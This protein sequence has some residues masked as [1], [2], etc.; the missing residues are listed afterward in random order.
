MAA[1]DRRAETAGSG[2]LSPTRWGAVWATFAGGVAAGA[3]IG[4]APPSLPLV[5]EEMSLS[6]VEVG[7]VATLFNLIGG[8]AGLAAG[9]A[10]DRW[11]QQRLAVAGLLLLAVGGL[12]GATSTGYGALL[13]ARFAEGAGF[14]VVAAAAPVLVA[15]AAPAA[16]DRAR[17]LALWSTYMPT[18]ATLALAA[19]A[20][21]LPHLGWRGLWTA[22]ALLAAIGA[23][24][25]ARY[26][27]RSAPHASGSL[28]L[29]REAFGSPGGQVLTALFACY[30]AQW[31]SV[32]IWLPTYVSEELGADAA[33]AAAVAALYV[34][35]N[36]PGNL[37]GG[38]LIARGLV[39]GN[40]IVAAA[41]AGAILTALMFAPALPTGLRFVALLLYSAVLGMIPA[42][43]FSGV[44]VL[45]R[46]PHHV[47][48][49]NGLVMQGS[50]LAQLLAPV[51]LAAL[52]GRLGWAAFAT[53]VALFAAGA[54]A[55]GVGVKRLEAARVHG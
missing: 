15:L 40:V 44:P 1:Q 30:V 17:A 31:T 5:R 54:I 8:V 19:A 55:C 39:R 50:Q 47:G 21:I 52:V 42:A 9:V 26:V 49:T 53:G 24:L 14:I 10:C 27:P 33:R 12:A 35:A 4:K 3:A 7:L 37:A 45:A 22:L 2:S 6:L 38:W 41:T 13:A 25:A 48:A 20:F 23:W 11:G 51:A 28:R 18:G 34:L 46:S 29:A 32:M 43:I 36:I 16:A